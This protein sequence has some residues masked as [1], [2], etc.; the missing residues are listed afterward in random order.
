VGALRERSHGGMKIGGCRGH[1][2]LRKGMRLCAKRNG[3]R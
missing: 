1:K 3:E 2:G